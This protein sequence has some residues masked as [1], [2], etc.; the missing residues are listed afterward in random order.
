M[1]DATPEQATGGDADE[2]FEA[3][4]TRLEA[5][6]AQ[7]E[8][9]DLPLE[10]SVELYAEGMRIAE[11]CQRMLADASQRVE[12]LREAYDEAQSSLL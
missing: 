8:A 12:R 2:S 10:R 1:P 6:T 9:G 3:L 11:R 7:L 5:I 4:F